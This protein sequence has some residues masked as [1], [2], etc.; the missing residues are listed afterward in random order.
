MDITFF[1]LAISDL[2]EAL[3]AME[4]ADTMY[5]GDDNDRDKRSAADS[6]HRSTFLNA[7][8]GLRM[9]N[10]TENSAALNEYGRQ[11]LS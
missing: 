1:H 11:N 10:G 8:R 9:V 3:E 6:E 5:R 7:V 2:S 4:E